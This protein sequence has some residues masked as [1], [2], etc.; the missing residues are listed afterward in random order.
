MATSSDDPLFLA[1]LLMY[2]PAIPMSGPEHHIL[3]P[4]ILLTVAHNVGYEMALESRLRQVVKRAAKFGLGSCA[5]IGACGAAMG[6]PIAVSLLMRADYT[7]PRERRS[8]LNA[9]AVAMTAAANLPAP[10]CC[11]ASVYSSLTVGTA[12]LSQEM[13]LKIPTISRLSCQF[14]DYNPECVGPECP[15]FMQGLPQG[16]T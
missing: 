8:V 10:R 16:D 13:G 9:S 14:R 5:S 11:K 2:H 12:Y 1:N 3:V 6:V 15:F 4:A 7:K